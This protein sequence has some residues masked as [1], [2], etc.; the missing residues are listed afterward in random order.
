VQEIWLPSYQDSSPLDYFV[1][2]FCKLQV[3][4]TPH[5]TYASL[6]KIKEVMGNID[7][8]TDARACQDSGDA[9]GK[10]QFFKIQ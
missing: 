8:D 4:R 6:V 3:N 9:G 2:G 1:Q 5:N 10:L 7:R